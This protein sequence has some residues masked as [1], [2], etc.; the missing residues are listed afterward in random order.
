M[1]GRREREVEDDM[2]E[3]LTTAEI[4][5]LMALPPRPPPSIYVVGDDAVS[6]I[7]LPRRRPN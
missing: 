7:T 5:A 3:T 2:G 4:D 1:D 6:A